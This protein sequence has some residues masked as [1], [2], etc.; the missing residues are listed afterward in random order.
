M[1][2]SGVVRDCCSVEL[3]AGE[4][5]LTVWPHPE[6]EN[7]VSLSFFKREWGLRW[8]KTISRQLDFDGSL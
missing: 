8:L 1:L 4:W 7:T 2:F 3:A 5:H 6:V